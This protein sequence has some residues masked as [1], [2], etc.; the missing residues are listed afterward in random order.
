MAD[1]ALMSDIKRAFFGS[2]ELT[3][4]HIAGDLGLE[5][6]TAGQD[7]HKS[8]I[9]PYTVKHATWQALR[10]SIISDNDALHRGLHFVK[11]HGFVGNLA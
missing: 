2:G 3:W 9:C 10:T 4:P 5:N 8:S 11:R 1:F 6:P 7:K